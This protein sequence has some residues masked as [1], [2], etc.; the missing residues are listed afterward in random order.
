QARRRVEALVA[1]RSQDLADALLVFLRDVRVDVVL[2]ERL[3]CEWRRSRR[4]RLSG[5][6]LFTRRIR[7]RH[8]TL[9]D[10]PERLA[11]L[12]L[13]D[14]EKALLPGLRADVDLFAVV[15]DRQ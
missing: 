7:L 6:G 15:P 5:R 4:E 1:R 14:V 12:A 11:G 10:R 2:G 3:P 13:E 8:G 9:L